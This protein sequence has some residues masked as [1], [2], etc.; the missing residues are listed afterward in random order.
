MA[1]LTKSSK[2]NS[3]LFN[4]GIYTPYDVINHL[5]NRY[6][7][8]GPRDLFRKALEW[9]RFLE[10]KNDVRCVVIPSVSRCG[11]VHVHALVSGSLDLIDSGM[12]YYLENWEHGFSVVVPISG[13]SSEIVEDFLRELTEETERI[14]G[15][16]YAVSKGV[17]L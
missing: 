15:Y 2:L 9:F 17:I 1:K 3:L 7:D 13:D 6:E 12:T 10:E 11:V 5:P 16:C 14:F 8:F 4:M